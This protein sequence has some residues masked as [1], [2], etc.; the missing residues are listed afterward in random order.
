MRVAD[1]PAC[2]VGHRGA[3]HYYSNIPEYYAAWPD[4][5]EGFDQSC[6]TC[7]EF[8]CIDDSFK[9]GYGASIDRSS[10]CKDPNKK[11]VVKITDACPCVHANFYSNQRWCCGDE[12]HIDL[13][14]KAYAE[15]RGASCNTLGHR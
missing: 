12:N 13:G 4:H 3:C 15:V 5:Q 6:G 8:Q 7:W 1:C 2:V 14:R 9:D 10:A 11:V